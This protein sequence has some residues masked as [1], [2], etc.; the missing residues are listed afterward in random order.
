MVYTS[1]KFLLDR[2]FL[3]IFNKTVYQNSNNSYIKYELNRK[4]KIVESED[5][6]KAYHK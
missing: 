1:S 3:Q 2:P 6:A 4:L 5:K